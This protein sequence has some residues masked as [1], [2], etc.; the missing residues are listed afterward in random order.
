LEVL[1]S[2]CWL[3]WRHGLLKAGDFGE[4]LR[5]LEGLPRAIGDQLRRMGMLD[6]A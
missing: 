4:M 3:A 5:R 2:R 6:F 1:N